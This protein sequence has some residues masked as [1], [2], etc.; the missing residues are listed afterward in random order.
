[1]QKFHIKV[2]KPS[3]DTHSPIVSG[4]PAPQYNS[5]TEMVAAVSHKAMEVARGLCWAI[6]FLSHGQCMMLHH[7]GSISY[8]VSVA[9]ADRTGAYSTS[10]ASDRVLILTC[11][12]ANT[13]KESQLKFFSHLWQWFSNSGYGTAS[14][15]GT[16]GTAGR[17][18]PISETTIMT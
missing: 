7:P 2:L 16:H 12:Q 11:M 3:L 5:S 14:G 17:L 8:G 18:S 15:I 4:L 13:H 1:M 10:R 6:P 9:P